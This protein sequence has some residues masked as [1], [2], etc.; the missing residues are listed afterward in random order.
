MRTINNDGPVY[1]QLDILNMLEYGGT[2]AKN[3]KNAMDVV[4]DEERGKV[5]IT[6]KDY[7]KK[8]IGAT[9]DSASVNMGAH[10]DILNQMTESRQCILKI[11]C[12]NYRIELAAKSVVT[13]S[14][15]EEEEQFYF[16]IT[17]DPS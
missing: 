8:M 16:F 11:N 15:F 1:L 7:Q 10:K 4:F 12:V 3:I 14:V 2:D 9:A 5:S 13:D 17:E 6:S